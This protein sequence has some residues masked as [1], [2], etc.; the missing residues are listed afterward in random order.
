MEGDMED[1]A[2]KCSDLWSLKVEQEPT[3]P[4]QL[5]RSPYIV[6]FRSGIP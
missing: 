6:I 5:Q 2:K 1:A 3:M 4:R